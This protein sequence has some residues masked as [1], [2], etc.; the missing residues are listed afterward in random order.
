MD[1]GEEVRKFYELLMKGGWGLFCS[2]PFS[3]PFNVVALIK[4]D[5]NEFKYAIKH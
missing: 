5:F 1:N 3:S 2:R 4:Y